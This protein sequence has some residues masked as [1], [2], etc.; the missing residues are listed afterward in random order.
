MASRPSQAITCP[1]RPRCVQKLS[2]R[3][4]EFRRL[5]ARHDVRESVS[6]TKTFRVPEVG[7]IDLHWDTYSL[8]GSPGPVMLVFTA[9]PGTAHAERLRLPGSLHASRVRRAAA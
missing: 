4:A 5:W 3:S 8:P 2:I 6:G 9:E 7:D 1:S